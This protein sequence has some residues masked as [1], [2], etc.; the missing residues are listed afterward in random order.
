M[1]ERDLWHWRICMLSQVHGERRTT[2]WYLICLL[3]M[4]WSLSRWPSAFPVSNKTIGRHSPLSTSTVGKITSPP[5]PLDRVAGPNWLTVWWWDY[6]G[7]W[8]IGRWFNQCYCIY[9]ATHTPDDMEDSVAVYVQGEL[10]L[11]FFPWLMV[12]SSDKSSHLLSSGTQSPYMHW[13]ALQTENMNCTCT[14]LVT[15]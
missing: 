14:N 3:V 7:W 10:F 8:F 12:V 5:P 9:L 11:V 15:S 2:T 4:E 13:M 6:I 1:K